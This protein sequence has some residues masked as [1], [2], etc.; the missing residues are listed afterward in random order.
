[1]TTLETRFWDIWSYPDLMFLVTDTP[2]EMTGWQ[3][4]EEGW[5]ILLKKRFVSLGCRI[6][7]RS[8]KATKAQTF[9]LGKL[10]GWVREAL[11][12]ENRS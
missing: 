11:P 2:D 8:Y 5:S 1:M 7:H 12:K 3:E 9:L 6:W 4:K 10:G